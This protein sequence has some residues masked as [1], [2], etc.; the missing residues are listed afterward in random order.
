MYEV[1]LDAAHEPGPTAYHTF[2]TVG[3][4]T[5]GL[6]VWDH[7]SC[8]GLGSDKYGECTRLVT[9]VGVMS[10]QYYESGNGWIDI[11]GTLYVHVGTAVWFKAIPNPEDACWPGYNPVWGGSSGASGTGE[12]TSVVFNTLSSSL[13]DFKTVTATCGTSTVSV[14]VIVYDFQGV[15]TPDDNFTGRDQM[16]YGIQETVDLSC[17]IVPNG[18]TGIQVGGL[19]WSKFMGAGFV[20]NVTD[21]GAA[22]YD[23]GPYDPFWGSTWLFLSVCSGPSSGDCVGYTRTIVAPFEAY[24]VQA[25]S[26]GIWHVQGQASIGFKGWIYLWFKNVSFSNIEWREE[27]CS[28]T[29]TGFFA[30]STGQIH[31]TG[32]WMGVGSG[33]IV[34]GCRVQCIDTVESGPHGGPYS[35]GTFTWPIPWQ[36]RVGA[37]GAVTF[38]TANHYEIIDSSGKMTIQKKWGGPFT[39]ELND[40][41]SD[42]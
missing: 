10:L 32:S 1:C 13:T 18:L 22:D 25:P 31:P 27:S 8:L 29:G 4:H 7:D 12:T 28:G 9:A 14:N 6:R 24:M 19:R 34:T 40:P 11:C 35:D 37:G 16:K 42:Y 26:T 3:N 20:S 2:E 41:D 38:A 5:V 39:R 30:P 33:N 21:N 36:Y 17:T 23:A 15:L